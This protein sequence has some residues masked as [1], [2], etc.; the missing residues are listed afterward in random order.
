M[1][2][3]LTIGR[4]FTT[5]GQNVYDTVEWSS[6]DSRIT[7]PDG[8]IVFEMLGAEI[9]AQWSQ[10]ASDIMVSKYFRKA[11]V[12]Q[13][14][15]AGNV[16][17]DDEGNPVTGSETSARQVIKRLASTWRWWGETN[18]YFATDADAEAFEDELAYMLLHQIAA[19]NSP[20]WF[21]NRRSRGIGRR[22]Q[23]SRPSRL[24]YQLRR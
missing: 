13:T 18:G 16:L 17:L 21:G 20:Q 1:G 5:E 14:D 4:R 6:R 19:P 23:P 15:A 10:V 11:G 12:P 7:N 24:L 8:S 9:P 22:L 2:Q 3:G